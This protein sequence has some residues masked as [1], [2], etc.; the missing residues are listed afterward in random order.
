MVFLLKIK[1]HFHIILQCLTKVVI[2][3]IQVVYLE[4]RWIFI[5][6]I[7]D[8]A[9]EGFLL[10]T[11]DFSR[12][13]EQSLRRMGFGN[14]RLSILV[15]SMGYTPLAQTKMTT[16]LFSASP[17]LTFP[18]EFRSYHPKNGENFDSDTKIEDL[19]LKYSQTFS[20]TRIMAN[21]LFI[22]IGWNLFGLNL[23]LCNL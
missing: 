16:A 18:I 22:K 14:S 5:L 17:K 3:W 11:S 6:F 9:L 20:K 12:Q 2:K 15:G 13:R 21:I 1:M 10:P 19:D 4:F 7:L 23:M 8:R